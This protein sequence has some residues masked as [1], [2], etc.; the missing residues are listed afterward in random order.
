MT[1]LYAIGLSLLLYSIVPWVWID[2]VFN[3]VDGTYAVGFIFY[4]FVCRGFVLI[5]IHWGMCF[6]CRGFY[7]FID[8][9]LRR[10]CGLFTFGCRGSVCNGVPWVYIGNSRA[11]VTIYAAT[12]PT[13]SVVLHNN[14]L[15]S[16]P[17]RPLLYRWRP[18]FHNNDLCCFFNYQCDAI[19]YQCCFSSDYFVTFDDLCCTSS[20]HCLLY[21]PLLQP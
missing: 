15:C 1:V 13:Y 18:M 12:V 20:D 2:L 19:I 4:T 7:L 11:P 8:I 6:R 3:G 5:C 16:H 21:R 10:E 14:N 17:Y 9:Q